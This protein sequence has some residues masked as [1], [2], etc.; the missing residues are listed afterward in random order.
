MR[1]TR[2][3]V[4]TKATTPRYVV[5]WDLHRQVIDCQQLVPAATSATQLRRQLHAL[6]LTAGSRKAI[7]ILGLFSRIVQGA[8]PAGS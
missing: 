3:D 5:L 7:Q 4:F 8:L 6:W 2:Y 1:R